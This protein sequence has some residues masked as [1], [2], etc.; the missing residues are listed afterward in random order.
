MIYHFNFHEGVRA[1]TIFSN[2]TEIWLCEDPIKVVK[3]SQA[4]HYIIKLL[5]I[6]DPKSLQPLLIWRPK[7]FQSGL[8]RFLF[9]CIAEGPGNF[10]VLFYSYCFCYSTII[11][12]RMKILL[13]VGPKVLVFCFHF[14]RNSRGFC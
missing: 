6:C 5:F 13:G 8:C 1:T 2:L 10:R 4:Q 12:L 9:L 11:S 3:A 14:L 7:V